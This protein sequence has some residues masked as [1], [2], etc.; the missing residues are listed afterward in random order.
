M[1]GSGF[2]NW[3]P[4]GKSPLS[5]LANDGAINSTN[6]GEEGSSVF[7]GGRRCRWLGAV[8]SGE[9]IH[10]PVAHFGILLGRILGR[11][12]GL[13]LGRVDDLDGAVVLLGRPGVV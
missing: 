3:S 9:G 4:Q 8:L 12:L 2:M 7:V 10:R 5:I 6:R 11:V 1:A 13:V